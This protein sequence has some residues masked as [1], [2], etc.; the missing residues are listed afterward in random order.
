MRIPTPCGVGESN[1]K[2]TA[3]ARRGAL[4]SVMGNVLLVEDDE[5]FREAL[6][7]V[8]AQRSHNVIQAS[9]GEHALKVL[10]AGTR[11]CVILSDLVMPRMDGAE[12][13]D[14]VRQHSQLRTIPMAIY[15]AHP[16]AKRR[17]GALGIRAVLRKPLD[18]DELVRI[19]DQ[20]CS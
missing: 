7:E 16:D 1:A 17:L 11:P 8:L 18:V 9:D 2:P 5:Q 14:R 13:W 15:S 3:R 12:L 10:N 20:Y 6:A 4:H 19:V